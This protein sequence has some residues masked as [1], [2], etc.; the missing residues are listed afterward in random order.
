MDSKIY[1]YSD[2]YYTLIFREVKVNAIQY[3]Q[4]FLN[5]KKIVDVLLDYNGGKLI[6]SILLELIQEMM[7]AGQTPAAGHVVHKLFDLSELDCPVEMDE[8]ALPLFVSMLTNCLEAH[9]ESS[10]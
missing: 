3:Q 8:Q 2:E 10:S 1:F 6:L 5:T 7:D 9:E 4:L